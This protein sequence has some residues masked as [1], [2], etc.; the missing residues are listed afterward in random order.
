MISAAL[1]SLAQTCV[2]S[3]SGADYQFDPANK[4]VMVGYVQACRK[5]QKGLEGVRIAGDNDQ[6]RRALL[7]I[8]YERDVL[9]SEIGL[10]DHKGALTADRK[11]L[12]MLASLLR[13]SKDPDEQNAFEQ[14]ID[15][16]GGQ[17]T[18]LE[19]ELKK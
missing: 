15:L 13:E 16:V 18:V 4:P 7:V 3:M 6:H 1:L 19:G 9:L 11:E 14:Q 10:D 5:A 2:A 12:N 17:I 8:L